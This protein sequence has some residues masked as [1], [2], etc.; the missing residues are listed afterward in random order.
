MHVLRQPRRRARDS[1]DARGERR[2]PRR[3]QE[4]RRATGLSP[5]R[6]ARRHH[7]AERDGRAPRLR[8]RLRRAGEPRLHERPTVRAYVSDRPRHRRRQPLLAHC[9]ALPLELR[10]RRGRRAPRAHLRTARATGERRARRCAPAVRYRRSS[11]RPA[12]VSRRAAGSTCRSR[13]PPARAA[14]CTSSSTAARRTRRRSASASSA[15]PGICPGPTPT[16][17]CSSFRRPS[18]TSSTT[19][20]SRAAP[21]RISRAAGTGSATTA[22]TSTRRAAS[23]R[24]AAV[25]RM[26]DRLVAAP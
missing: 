21:V 6:R 15:R 11:S 8:D 7:R 17:S 20:R 2:R 10:L 1:A 13:A 16:A 23:S 26:I 9:P 22:P 25:K 19:I 5:L 18:R 3:R 14:G 12:S 4:P 24:L